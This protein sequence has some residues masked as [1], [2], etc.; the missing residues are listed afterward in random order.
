MTDLSLLV[1][2]SLKWL[3]SLSEDRVSIFFICVQSAK[4][5]VCRPTSTIQ[6][7]SDDPVDQIANV[8]PKKWTES[9]L[10]FYKKKCQGQLMLAIIFYSVKSHEDNWRTSKITEVIRP[11]NCLYVSNKT[12][13][14][15][16]P[17]ITA[18]SDHLTFVTL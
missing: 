10:T 17:F 13:Q 2:D 6:R 15:L 4:T 14:K 18:E 9:D 11:I 3:E 16:K 8:Y 12:V 7:L 1:F 5:L